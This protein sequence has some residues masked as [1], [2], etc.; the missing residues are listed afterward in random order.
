MASKKKFNR[1]DMIPVANNTTG[2][3]VYINPRTKEKWVLN[4]YGDTAEW[5]YEEIATCNSTYPKIT[6]APWLL[7]LNDDVV[8]NLG[9]E[10]VYENI[11]KPEEV[12]KFI[13]LPNDKFKEFITKA[14]EGMKP[15]I[16]EVIKQKIENGNF[17]SLSKKRIVEEIYK[18]NFDDFI[19][20]KEIDNIDK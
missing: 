10:K 15:I 6:H 5:P 2:Q 17:D 8:K 16:V 19:Q 4:G 14:S 9:L 7:I 3:L 20:S 12:E 13:N 18:I 11:F 1:D